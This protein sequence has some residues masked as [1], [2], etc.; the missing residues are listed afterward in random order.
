VNTGWILIHA[1]DPRSEGWDQRV[2][3]TNFGPLICH[4]MIVIA[5][6]FVLSGNLIK[7]VGEGSDG[8]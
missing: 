4:P 8:S 2:S 7:V 1:I 3:W 6:S 5:Y